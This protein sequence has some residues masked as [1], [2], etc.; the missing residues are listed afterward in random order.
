MPSGAFDRLQTTYGVICAF[1]LAMAMS[2]QENTTYANLHFVTFSA[3][4]YKQQGF[5]TFVHQVLNNTP[6]GYNFTFPIGPDEWFDTEYELLTGVITQF[7][8][9]LDRPHASSG[10]WHDKIPDLIVYEPLRLLPTLLYPDWDS[11]YTEAYLLSH[12]DAYRPGKQGSISYVAASATSMLIGGLCTNI[13][14]YVA[15]LLSPAK[16]ENKSASRAFQQIALPITYYNYATLVVSVGCFS[17]ANAYKMGWE[18]PFQYFESYVTGYWSAGVS[19][20]VPL[21]ICLPLSIIAY[22]RSVKANKIKKDGEKQSV[23]ANKKDGEKQKSSNRVEPKK[24]TTEM[25]IQGDLSTMS[26]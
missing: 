18:T 7:P 20:A 14:I 22:H 19:Y 6:G 2:A 23:K 26:P 1:L 12:P 25:E 3:A 13:M 4:L 24:A 15:Y 10:Y 9:Q 16:D 5:R 8:W 11:R 21:L 17:Y